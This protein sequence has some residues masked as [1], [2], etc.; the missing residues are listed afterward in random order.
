MVSS[1]EQRADWDSFAKKHPSQEG[2]ERAK[3]VDQVVD[4][5]AELDFK[6]TPT[7]L[8]ENGMIFAGRPD[9]I[10]VL[11]QSFAVVKQTLDTVKQNNN[12]QE[13]PVLVPPLQ[14]FRKFTD[15]EL[16]KAQD[17]IDAARKKIE[18]QSKK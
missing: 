1:P 5:T 8:F 13:L 4:I 11:D 14:P 12:G 2:C 18:A 3:I 6:A 10:Q 16:K 17:E 9:N 15:E 7:L